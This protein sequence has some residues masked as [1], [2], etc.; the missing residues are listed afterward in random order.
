MIAEAQI[1]ERLL[2]HTVTQ[3]RIYYGVSWNDYLRL[4]GELG[5]G[6][7]LRLTYAEG[8]LEVMS[9]FIRA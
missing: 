8:V 2:D 6:S 7:R 9:P 1:I 5:D 4:L 3:R